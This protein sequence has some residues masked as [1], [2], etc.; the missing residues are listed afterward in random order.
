MKIKLWCCVGFD[1]KE[2]YY[3]LP[4]L[5]GSKKGATLRFNNGEYIWENY[6][7]KGWKCIKV[8]VTIKPINEVK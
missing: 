3:Y 8:E 7:K 4:S 6:K 2:P 1:F 5:A